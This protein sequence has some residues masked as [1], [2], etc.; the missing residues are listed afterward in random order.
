MPNNCPRCQGHIFPPE[1]DHA[2]FWWLLCSN[3]HRWTSEDMPYLPRKSS[4]STPV[5]QA[6]V[7][8]CDMILPTSPVD[9]EL[10]ERV[11]AICRERM[12][13]IGG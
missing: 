5:E 6:E 12:A 8:V 9:P 10:L 2:G 3:G 11:R 1:W 13:G 4:R 7:N